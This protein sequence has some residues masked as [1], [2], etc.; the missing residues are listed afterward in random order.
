MVISITSIGI[1]L[2]ILP[3]LATFPGNGAKNACWYLLT[4]HLFLVATY[5]VPTSLSITLLGCHP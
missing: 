1:S 2:S 5:Y 4:C 3:L